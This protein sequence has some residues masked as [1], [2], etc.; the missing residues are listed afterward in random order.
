[1][2]SHIFNDHKKRLEPI[3]AVCIFCVQ[4]QVNDADTCYLTL[5]KEKL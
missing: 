3:N 2:V 5:Y 4:R 1:M